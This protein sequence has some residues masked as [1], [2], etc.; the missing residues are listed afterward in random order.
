MNT[1]LAHFHFRAAI[2]LGFVI[3][4]SFLGHS[5][6]V[7][8]SRRLIRFDGKPAT[9]AKVRVLSDPGTGNK[10]TDL[11]VIADADGILSFDVTQEKSLWVGHIIVRAE[12]CAITCEVAVTGRPKNQPWTPVLRLGA[13]FNIEGRTEDAKGRPVAEAKVSLIWAQAKHWNATT[14][15]STTTDLTTTPELIAHSTTN[16]TWSMLGIDFLESQDPIEASAVFEAVADKPL[17]ASKLDLQLAP[18]P[19]TEPRKNIFLNFRL[20]PLIRVAGKVVNSVTGK[21]VAGAYLERGV[22]FT[23][24]AGSSALTDEAGRFELRIPGPLWGIW[25][26]VYR[27]GFA[28]TTVKTASRKQATSDWPE[29]NDL[30]LRVRP[31]VAVSGTLRDENGKPPDEPLELY[32]NYEERIDAEWDQ[33]GTGAASESRT[34]TD[35]TFSAKLPAGRITVGVRGSTIGFGNAPAN[36]RLKQQV[37]IPADGKKGWLLKASRIDKTK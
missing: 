27:D 15:N 29:T 9:G 16:G 1:L 23:T 12:G 4:L 5:E 36:Y 30:V 24:L 28:S 35:G 32:A 22:L 19:G 7:T 31:M 13:P 21:A 11:E 14:F 33:E 20:A 18:Q 17:R 26:Q 34:A 6:V 2:S 37:N 25:F 10:K 3:G 8:V